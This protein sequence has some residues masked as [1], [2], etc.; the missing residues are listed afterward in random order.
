MLIKALCDYYDILAQENKIL[1]DDYSNVN[2]HYLICLSPEGKIE[3]IIDYRR[4]D[5]QRKKPKYFP[6][7]EVFPKRSEKPAIVGNIIDHRPRYIFGLNFDNGDFT[8]YDEKDT[9][10]KSHAAFV[11][12]NLK[13]IESMDSPL[14]NAYRNFLYTWNP[15]K[16]TV[17]PH[18][19]NLGANFEKSGYA[20]CLMGE[21]EQMLHNDPLIR[22]KW[23]KRCDVSD[24]EH[25]A[26]CAVTG[27]ETEIARIHDKIKGVYNSGAASV[28]IGYNNPSE[29]SYGN[30]QSY[31]S[32]ISTAAMKKYTKALNYLLASPKHTIVLDDMTIVFWAMNPN[33]VYEDM[34][35]LS[36][37][38][39]T[40]EMNVKETEGM[41][42][43][44]FESAK[45]GMVS[46]EK[47]LS[48]EGIDP[49]IDF[50]IL[51][52]SPNISRLSIKFLYKKTFAQ[53]LWNIAEFQKDLQITGNSELIPF[54]LIKEELL[55]PNSDSEKVNPALIAKTI[56]SAFFGKKYP[57]SLLETILRRVKTDKKKPLNHVRAGI[58]KA[59][60]NRN[61]KEEYGLA[62]DKENNQQAYLCGRLFSVL[63]K[64]QSDASSTILNR[65]IKDSY[66][67]SAATTPA[68]VFPTLM[69]LAQHHIKK[70]KYPKYY[71]IL[72]GE[73]MDKINGNFPETFSLQAQGEFVV[74]Y[75]Q[76]KQSFYEK[77]EKEKENGN[78]KQL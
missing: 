67:S 17:N 57:I 46:S 47:L 39:K 55:S 10:L 1:S 62:L 33:E 34:L 28:L 23:E 35:L 77:K 4:V 66:F 58:I 15:E 19:L 13:F 78:E 3:R 14:I 56:E 5:Q 31:N 45:E 54:G 6:R 21:P 74:G 76:Q 2:I 8:P 25:I 69:K 60:L 73:I 41:I 30:K 50:Y 72:I 43:D 75:Y 22:E 49:D 12:A 70:V 61:Y 20:F 26:Q 32:N 42:K 37:F 53:V 7:T 68:Y 51:G 18:L 38:G 36:L 52:L 16:E 29:R 44:L 63:E 65:T 24:S 64:L 40:D 71:D 9:A 59:C 48:D 11:E 27:E